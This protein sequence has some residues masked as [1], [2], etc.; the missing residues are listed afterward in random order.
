MNV[1]SLIGILPFAILSFYY[2]SHGMLIIAVNGVLFHTFS[3][4]KILYFVDFTTNVILYTKSALN[5]SFIFKYAFFS[6]FVFLLNNHYFKKY[7][8]LCEIIH[9][10]F[11]QWISLAAIIMVYYKDKCFP[12][13]FLC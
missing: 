8:I 12:T 6:L 5:F 7:K 1:I 11:V 4:N 13:L 10:I 3:N 9:V 2:N